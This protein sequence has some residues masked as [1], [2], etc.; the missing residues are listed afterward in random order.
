MGDIGD[1]DL[2]SWQGSQDIVDPLELTHESQSTLDAKAAQAEYGDEALQLQS[3]WM[4]YI[5][6]QYAPYS[7]VGVSALGSQAELAGL[8]GSAAQQAAIDQIAQ[9]PLYQAKVS[10]GDEAVMRNAAMT[11]GLRSG[12]VQSA[13]ATQN[14]ALLSDEIEAQYQQL[15]GLSGQGFEGTNVESQTG[16][17]A[18]DSMTTTLGTLS[19]G[20]ASQQAA[21]QE[22][23]TGILGAVGSFFSDERLKTN[24]IKTG[25]RHG[26]PWY[27]WLW[28]DKAN[29]L[30]VFGLAEG[31]MAGEVA[32]KYPDLVGEHKGFKTVN[33]GGFN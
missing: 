2:F 32:I 3:D 16:T 15:A 33:Y 30:G 4:Q 17:E 12:N 21:E 10:A 29:S 5:Q 27:T 19:S 11:G 26:L 8:S 24:I 23:T 25:E 28:N 1:L 18:I 9:D 13:L 31:H 6:D 22:Q 7:E 14:Q 20:V